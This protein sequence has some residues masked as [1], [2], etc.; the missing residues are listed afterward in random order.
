M[1]PTDRRTARA[2]GAIRFKRYV[3]GTGWPLAAYLVSVIVAA[4]L[5]RHMAPGWLRALASMLP[6]PAIVWLARAELLRLRRCDELRQRIELEAMAIAF[7]ISFGTIV[8]LALLDVFGTLH[9]TLT[10]V[11]LFMTAC[12]IGTQLWVRARYR[13][14]CVETDDEEDR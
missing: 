4:L 14:A 13:Y 8:M 11:S 10:A 9:I 7:S 6:L 3:A 2:P 1:H 5:S 12:W